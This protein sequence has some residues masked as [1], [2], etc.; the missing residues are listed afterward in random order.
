VTPAGA[1][2]FA[3]GLGRAAV[4]AGLAALVAVPGVGAQDTRM[5]VSAALVTARY[6]APASTS[7]D[8]RTGFGVGVFADVLVTPLRPLRVRVGG[9]W[10]RRG[11]DFADGGGAEMDLLDVP[12]SVGVRLPIGPAALRPTAGVAVA[13]PIRVRRSPDVEAGFA[14][15]SRGEVTGFLGL[16]L[17]VDLPRDLRLGIEGRRVRGLSAAFEGRAG[18]LETR[19]TE[20]VVRVSRPW[21]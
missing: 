13:Y 11:G 17:E 6:E 15:D 14:E 9:R 20:L 18:R 1:L 4:A 7:F 16:D 12:L 21:G 8:D 3:C 5:G 2:S 10:L 19:A